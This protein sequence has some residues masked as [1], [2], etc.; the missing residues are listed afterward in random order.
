MF[1]LLG[2]GIWIENE[3][4][5]REAREGRRKKKK[6]QGLAFVK[7]YM[8][9]EFLAAILPIIDLGL[10]IWIENEPRR[11][12]AREGRR[13]KKKIQGLAFVKI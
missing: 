10:G 7:I 5:R 13:K 4:R 1:C 11:R 8:S 2:L 12:E 3:P 6:I 9:R